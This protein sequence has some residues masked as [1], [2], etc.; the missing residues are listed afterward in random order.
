MYGMV[1]Q[2]PTSK[3]DWKCLR[4]CCFPY[5]RPPFTQCTKPQP[6]ELYM[7]SE[8]TSTVGGVVQYK[9]YCPGACVRFVTT[10]SHALSN[11]KISHGPKSP[12]NVQKGACPVWPMQ[13]SVCK[14]SY[15]TIFSTCRASSLVVND[16]GLTRCDTRQGRTPPLSSQ[17]FPS[18]TYPGLQHLSVSW[19]TTSKNVFRC[20]CVFVVY[21]NFLLWPTHLPQL[22]SIISSLPVRCLTRSHQYSQQ[23][24]SPFMHTFSLI[25]MSFGILMM[26]QCRT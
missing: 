7:S 5:M 16:G 8:L 23:A 19:D 26:A 14:R 1:K 21:P 20:L 2:M 11:F 12:P 6:D 22:L 4:R 17:C 24:S 9:G 18:V 13:T 25:R 3:C 15:T 10:V